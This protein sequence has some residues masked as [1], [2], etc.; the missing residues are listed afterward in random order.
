VGA[1]LLFLNAKSYEIKETKISGAEYLNLEKIEKI[2]DKNLSGK[3][4]FFIKN[5]NFLF[6]PE[7]NLKKELKENFIEIKNVDILY[8][9]IFNFN[10]IDINIEQKDKKYL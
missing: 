4:L 3:N 1:L 5:K 10:K 7:S 8:K 2:V 9:N 6:Y